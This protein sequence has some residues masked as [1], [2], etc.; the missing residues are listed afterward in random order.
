MSNNNYNDNMIIW[1]WEEEE[2]E[3]EEEAGR[4]QFYSVTKLLLFICCYRFSEPRAA[5]AQH[6]SADRRRIWK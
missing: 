3:E 6:R 2:E 4:E 1:I 5:R